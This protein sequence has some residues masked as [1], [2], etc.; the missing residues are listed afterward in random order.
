MLF[1]CTV[2]QT[3]NPSDALKRVIISC[4]VTDACMAVIERMMVPSFGQAILISQPTNASSTIPSTS[5]NS[6]TIDCVPDIVH[7][8]R[9]SQ[10]GV[11]AAVGAYDRKMF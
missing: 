1:I 4:L 11:S 3:I 8:G 9:E 5:H 2:V 6:E 10:C 7:I